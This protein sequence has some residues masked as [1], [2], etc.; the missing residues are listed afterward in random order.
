[1]DAGFLMK[2]TNATRQAKHRAKGRPV[3]FTIT[4][5]DA[6]RNLEALTIKHG[7]LKAAIEHALKDNDQ[8]TTQTAILTIIY[9]MND[10]S[11]ASTHRKFDVTNEKNSWTNAAIA[12]LSVVREENV[13]DCVIA[14]ELSITTEKGWLNKTYQPREWKS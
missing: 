6:I 3:S 9:R 11:H 7:G 10:G 8:M 1:M 2:S 14:A 4:D 13:D 12:G 5:P